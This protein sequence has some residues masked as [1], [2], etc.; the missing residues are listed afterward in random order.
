[1]NTGQARGACHGVAFYPSLLNNFHLPNVVEKICTEKCWLFPQRLNLSIIT[2]S[3]EFLLSMQLQLVSTV[4]FYSQC[5]IFC[6]V[7]EKGSR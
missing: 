1:M 6:T 2:E 4:R 7:I 3:M 5:L